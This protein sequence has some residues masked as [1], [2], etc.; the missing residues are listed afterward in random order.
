MLAKAFAYFAI[1]IF[2]TTLPET[3]LL[4]AFMGEPGLSTLPRTQFDP[5]AQ[6]LH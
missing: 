1:L 2:K 3:S 5:R 4:F 6:V